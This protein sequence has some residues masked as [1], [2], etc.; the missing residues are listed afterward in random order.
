MFA[1]G[2]LPSDSMVVALPD[3]GFD[4]IVELIRRQAKTPMIALDRE[5]HRDLY[6]KAVA[7]SVDMYAKAGVPCIVVDEG[8]GLIELQVRNMPPM[9]RRLVVVHVLDHAGQA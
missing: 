7:Y 6:A 5:A 1:I 3:I 8:A 2:A 9:R 4:E